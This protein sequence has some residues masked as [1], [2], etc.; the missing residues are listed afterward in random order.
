MD[1]FTDNFNPGKMIVENN[2][3]FDNKRFNY[4]FRINPYFSAEEQ[5]TF[6]N[7][8]SFRTTSGIQDFVS[9]NVDETNYFY[10][11]EK[12]VNSEGKAVS[13]QDLVDLTVPAKFER[14]Q[15]GNILYG[16]FL[17]PTPESFLNNAGTDNGYVGAIPA[18]PVSISV[19]GPKSLREGETAQLVIK[20]TYFDGSEKVLSSGLEFESAD[21]S[22]ASVDQ[23]GKVQGD[24]KG[25]TQ[26]S[27]SYNGL[28]TM[29]ELHVKQI[30]QGLKKK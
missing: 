6:R 29:L 21:T 1:G 28:S 25:K 18:L 15:K 10:D 4:V 17:R 12:T 9:G 26:I 27:V 20:A 7:N 22:I 16:N 5:G 3:S 30:P 2:T 24:S 14:D 13:V 11:G 19:E 8:L 23:E